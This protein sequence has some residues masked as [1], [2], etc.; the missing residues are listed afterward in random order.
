[1][2]NIKLFFHAFQSF[3]AIGKLYW[4]DSPEKWRAIGLLILLLCFLYLDSTIGVNQLKQQ[5]EL[6]SAL[7]DRD[8]ERFWQSAFLYI[9]ASIVLAVTV[10]TW[11]YLEDK[12]RLYSREFLTK[13]YLDKYFQNN[14]F[15]KV[16]TFYRE[17]DNPDQRITEDI[18]SFCH[19]SVS[20]FRQFTLAII[21][22]VQF[23]ILLW[24]KS[25]FLVLILVIYS[26]GGMLI[27]T[28]GFGKILIP[29]KKEQLKREA[30][31]RFGLVR[32]RENAESIAFYNGGN[33]EFSY[34]KQIFAPVL[35]IYNKV[36]TW[37]RNLDI[38]Q[39]IYGYITWI[40]PPLV[41]G[42]RILAGEPGLEV[43]AIPEAQGAFGRV[44]KSLNIIVRMFEFLTSFIAG[45]ER[46]E[47]FVKVLE[48]S[49]ASPVEGSQTI[50]TVEDSHLSL[51]DLTLQTPNYQR[52][53]VK[54][55]SIELQPGEG[56]LIVGVSGGGKSSILRAIAGLWNSGSG[57]IY[58]PKL[59]EILFLPQ[60]PYLILGSLRDQLLYPRTDL[61]IADAEICRVLEEVNLPDLAE[62]FGGLDTVEDW[63]SVLS[64]GEQQRVAFGRLLL[65]KPRYAILDEAT[66]ALDVQNEQSL[67]QHLQ[68][69]ST[70]YISVGHRPTLLQYHHQVLEVLGDETWRVSS[71]QD[72][73]FI[74][75]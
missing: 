67:Y 75:T 37:E 50:D 32:I 3:W 54:N 33:R 22:L 41:I 60:R 62:R 14:C 5:G 35:S 16:N 2:K 55:V 57:K 30:N 65:T 52:T 49:E 29:I 18:A 23:G 12:I 73:Q 31:F 47:S 44:F 25:N 43:G 39:N 68:S 24:E 21:N 20:L 61:N 56:L 40:L 63:D 13:Y 46:L 66:S 26:L 10:A 64:M 74:R 42:L 19:R 51:Q 8:S 7:V 34:I 59:A 48:E 70:T 4:W 69:L 58:R 53:L 28:I 72:Y 17:I 45:I 15:Y 71:A 38:F 6:I 27:T 9:G 1:M 36:I 11:Q